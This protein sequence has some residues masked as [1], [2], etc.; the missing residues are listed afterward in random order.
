MS[1]VALT[2]VDGTATS[3]EA[4]DV[5]ATLTHPYAAL[6]YTS[7]VTRVCL[8]GGTIVD[9]RGARATIAATIAAATGALPSRYATVAVNGPISNATAAFVLGAKLS[10]PASTPAGDYIIHWSAIVGLNGA[11]GSPVCRTRVD[12]DSTTDTSADGTLINT[13]LHDI[14]AV[15]A[16]YGNACQAGH[17]IVTLTAAAHDFRIKFLSNGVVNTFL[18]TIRLTAWRV[19]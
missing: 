3:I 7:D 5:V 1:A 15:S 13:Q 8:R 17:S 18:Q 4:D 19:A 2:L 9:V 10:L 16:T 6:I 12:L 14:Y 11:A